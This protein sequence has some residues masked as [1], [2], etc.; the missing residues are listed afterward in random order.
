MVSWRIFSLIFLI[1]PFKIKCVIV[2]PLKISEIQSSNFDFSN[3][4]YSNVYTEVK[5]GKPN[6]IIKLYLSQSYDQSY[7]FHKD[8]KGAYNP[9]DSQTYKNISNINYYF[10]PFDRGI[11]ANETMTFQN[12]NNT[13]LEVNDFTFDLVTEIKDS[14]KIKEGIMG[15]KLFDNIYRGDSLKNIIVQLKKRHLIETYGWSMK[16]GKN[17]EGWLHIGGYPHEYNNKD[18]KAEY[19]KHVYSEKRT[20]GINWEIKFSDIIT[21]EGNYLDKVRNGMMEIETGLIFGS[22]EYYEIVQKEFFNEKISKKQCFNAT[23]TK[24]D[25]L[26]F[27]YYYCTDYEAIKS[28]KGIHFKINDLNKDF[29]FDYNDLFLKKDNK[30]YFLIAFRPSTNVY[31]ILGYPFFKKYEFVFEPDKKLIG[32]YFDYPKDSQSIQDDNEEKDYTAVIILIVVVVVLLIIITLLIFF[33]YKLILKKKKAR[34]NELDD[35]FE[36]K[37]KQENQ[38]KENNDDKLI[39]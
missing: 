23:S 7:I 30:Y 33:I 18:Y 37:E 36:Y 2:F 16:F 5:V 34:A 31:W 20:T 26:S 1:I 6:Q 11:E 24:T 8:I 13:N 4:E 17:G 38:D 10:G 19:F 32:T 21:G 29:F 39:N 14:I 35:N 15:F 27:K 28:F 9:K 3:L 12:I 22:D 25:K